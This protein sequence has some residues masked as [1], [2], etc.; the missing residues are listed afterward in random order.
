[1][2][3][4][5]GPNAHDAHPLHDALDALAPAEVRARLGRWFA[6]QDDAT[7]TSLLH[8][9]RST[10]PAAPTLLDDVTAFVADAAR[11]G[12]GSPHDAQALLARVD[13]V[14][15]R[16][17]HDE[18]RRAWEA[19]LRPLAASE[20][21]LGESVTL[22]E[23]V[24][25][26]DRV[27][28]RYLVSV[29]ESAPAPREQAVW[30]ALVTAHAVSSVREPLAAM[31]SAATVP[32]PGFDEFAHAWTAKL[33]DAAPSA[34]SSAFEVEHERWLREAVARTRGADGLRALAMRTGRP[35]VFDH[36][37]TKL[38]AEGR[39]DDALSA[40]ATAMLTVRDGAHRAR[41]AERRVRIALSLGRTEDAHHALRDAWRAEPTVPRLLR[42][43]TFGDPPS[44]VLVERVRSLQPE[45]PA[46][47]E[48]LAGV[49]AML[50]GA[51]DD[52]V[53][54]LAGA[55]GLGWSDKRHP[56]HTLFAAVAK[57][58]LGRLHTVSS[59]PRIG[60]AIGVGHPPPDTVPQGPAAV[61]DDDD[62]PP[63]P[64][65]S[66]G[67]TLDRALRLHPLNDAVR[68]AMLDALRKAALRR[69]EDATG[70]Q[71]RSAY[72]HAACLVTVCS[73][74]HAAV[75]DMN[76]ARMFLATV[77]TQFRSYPALIRTLQS[78]ASRSATV[79]PWLKGSQG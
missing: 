8:A 31:T 45:V 13:V 55:R 9:L 57:T 78:V 21:S 79:A 20:L 35:A 16:G 46:A 76:G 2:H 48:R 44:H 49:V 3:T 22:A 75:G 52:A 18:A 70:S 41:Y 40:T 73:E 27:V 19:L 50:L 36:W 43:A 59:L 34:R 54:I 71:R 7:Q 23:A 58:L 1:M 62:L 33:E 14:Y 11:A 65:V 30:D 38:R 15:E 42:V 5:R 64:E 17:A 39:P 56:G 25:T 61:S 47:D 53:K 67:D 6:A 32:L 29:Y 72:D 10:A 26:L 66:L 51:Y 24:P 12:K 60:F 4:G 77:Q 69:A 74:A 37:I 63:L 68:R 28:A